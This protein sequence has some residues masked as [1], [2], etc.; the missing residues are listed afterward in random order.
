MGRPRTTTRLTVEDC[1]PLSVHQIMPGKQTV[2]WMQGEKKLA[3]LDYERSRDAVTISSQSISMRPVRTIDAHRLALTTTMQWRNKSAQQWFLCG[4][5]KRVAKMY[6]AP[7][8]TEFRCRHCLRLTYRSAQQHDARENYLI[9]HPEE[10][11]KALSDPR[12]WKLAFR[13]V[14]RASLAHER[15]RHPEDSA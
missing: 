9:R 12:R 10:L 11:Q 7:S 8:Q 6:L 3:S 13:A 1:L 14:M 2:T 4:C 15:K 5:G